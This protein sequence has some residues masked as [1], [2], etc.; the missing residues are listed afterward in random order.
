[1]NP[2]TARTSTSILDPRSASFLSRQLM[3]V[4]AI[5]GIA[6]I[7]IFAIAVPIL[8]LVCV[9]RSVDLL[10]NSKDGVLLSLGP[11][12]I[13]FGFTMSAILTGARLGCL[14]LWATGK[15]ANFAG[16][17]VVLSL[18]GAAFLGDIYLNILYLGYHFGGKV[19]AVLFN[20]SITWQQCFLIILFSALISLDMLAIRIIRW[21]LEQ[22]D[23]L[24][25]RP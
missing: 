16:R 22:A 17:Y 25:H 13:T 4:S 12:T 18:M 6:F 20:E 8:D 7:G 15:L 21:A 5:F 9:G 10:S 24:A 11:L 19:P 3:L 14:E 1:M 2:Q 23:D